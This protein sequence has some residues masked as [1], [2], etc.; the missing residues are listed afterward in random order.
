M[1]RPDPEATDLPAPQLEATRCAICG[2]LG[3]IATVYESN[4]RAADLTSEVF[5]ARRSPDRLHY[6]I[7][8]C[9]ACGLLRSDPVLSAAAI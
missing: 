7:V 8:R 2:T 1:P 4:F 5:S 3:N 6:R 9:R